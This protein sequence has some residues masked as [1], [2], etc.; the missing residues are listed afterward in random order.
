LATLPPL[1]KRITEAAGARGINVG[2]WSSGGRSSPNLIEL[3]TKPKV[4]VVYVKEFNTAGRPGFWGLTRNQVNRL[5]KGDVRWFAILLLRSSAAG[6]LLTSAEVRRL[7]TDGSF[8]LSDD[9]DYKVNE[10]I[11]L[12][13]QQRFQS[14]AEIIEHVI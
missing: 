10:N 14:V 4:T 2:A 9:G 6:Y 8:E 7:I 3:S 11:D 1:R 13:P 5:E 12:K